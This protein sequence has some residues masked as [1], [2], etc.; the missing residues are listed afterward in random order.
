M[1]PSLA[2]DRT[3]D[4]PAVLLL[5]GWPGDRH[6]YAALE[7]SGFDAIAPDLLGFGESPKPAGGD[8][9][10]AGEA[11][12]VLTLLDELGVGA[13][14][15]VGYDIGSRVAQQLARD[16]PDRVR[17]L[18]LAPPL[19][20]VGERILGEGPMREFWYQAFHRLPLSEQLLDGNRE[21]IRAYLRHFW[22]H[23]SG[24]GFEPSDEL[25]DRLVDTYSPPGAFTAS[26]EW[27][28]AGSGSVARALAETP[29]EERIAQPARILW[30]EHD[31]LFP[32]EWGDRTGEFFADAT[33][34][35]L[36]GV[37][38]FSPLEAPEAYVA[39]IRELTE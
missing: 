26:I 37:G 9:S 1:S 39:A 4:G 11:R 30:P 18:V 15:V 22:S 6:D 20:G 28:R 34:T 17:A 8:Y 21:A 16:A 35:D 29:P 36:P 19:P 12:E 13:A 38:H 14:T 5:H 27:Y 25:L 33:I 23:W 3:G 31:P 2:F 10:A 7:L 24:P 32:R